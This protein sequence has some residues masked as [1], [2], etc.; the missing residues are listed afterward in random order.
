MNRLTIVSLFVSAAAALAQTAP[1]N[2]PAQT[3][4]PAPPRASASAKPAAGAPSYK[5]LKFPPLR[6]IS[7]PKV[8]RATL[9][10]GMR[11]YLLEDHEIPMVHGVALVRTGNLFDPQDKI[12]LAQFTG[13]VLRTGGT[14]AKTGDQIDQQLEDVAAS[15]ESEIGETS[16]SVGFT[17]L[18][19]NAPEVMTVFHDLLTA[20]EFRQD[21][22]DLTKSQFRSAIS[23]RNDNPPTVAAREFESVVYGRDN[24][25]GWQ[26]SYATINAIT[27]S[28]LQ[29]F[30]KRYFFPKNVMLAVWGDFDSAQMKSQVEKLFADWTIEQP[31]VP[32]FPQVTAKDSSGVYLAVKPDLTQTFFTVGGLGGELRDKDFPALEVLADILGGG[33]HSRLM[34][35]VRSRMGNAYNI[36]ANWGASYDHPGLFRISGSTGTLSTVDTIT[37]ILKEVDRIRTSEVTDEELKTAKESALNSM[38]FAYDTRTK[39]L[40]RI[41]SYEYYGYP[42]DFINQ[43]QKALAD[44]TR[45]D[46]LRV[47]KEH[48]DPAKLAIVALGNPNGFSKPLDSLGKPVKSIDLTIPEP[49]STSASSATSVAQG[50]QLLAAAQEAVGG[51]AKLAAVKDFVET[52]QMNATN[53]N[54][55]V[56]ETIK[57]VAPNL[58][59]EENSFPGRKVSVY[60]DGK[61][62]WI[63]SGAA[64]QALG[65]PAA[66]QANGDLFRSYIG[67]LLSDRAET[68]TVNAIDTHALEI[69]DKSGNIVRLILDPTTH[70]P[71]SVS[72]DATT[73]TG[74]PPI[75]QETYSDFRD[76][77]GIKVPF[78]VTLTQNGQPYADFT[79]TDFKIN[80]GLTADEIQKRP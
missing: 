27:R 17:A 44:V 78:K 37:A 14:A 69:T 79:I 18:K 49:T 3:P 58:L 67:L 47:A 66:K 59:R 64:S 8:E 23:R 7:I 73:V 12:G 26:E 53:P 36:S 76:I 5:D 43:F 74:A 35:I 15:V 28:D 39:T 9:P 40:Q 61:S 48:I 29:G 30:Y 24:P 63:A 10:N 51:A 31:Q 19:E 54:V 55:H 4:R 16:G 45:A 25:Y 70:M 32:A 38:V 42:P 62:G 65:G 20:P 80:T 46:I 71:Q 52:A 22:L 13:T 77:G 41:L 6:P 34:E 60:T 33:F 72:Y 1:P 56:E 50:K 75:V 68:R 21:K 57:W 11:L 2:A